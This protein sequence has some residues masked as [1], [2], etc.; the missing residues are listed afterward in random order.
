MAACGADGIV[1]EV[2]ENPSKALTEKQQLLDY[3]EF[4]VMMKLIRRI[5]Y[6]TGRTEVSD[7]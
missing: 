1:V 7:Q 5:L 2:H 4:E 6:A 3:S